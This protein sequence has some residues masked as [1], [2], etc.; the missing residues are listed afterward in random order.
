MDIFKK[1]LPLLWK[2][3]EKSKFWFIQEPWIYWLVKS[4]NFQI[5]Y[6]MTFSKFAQEIYFYLLVA[7]LYLFGSKSNIFIH[8][9]ISCWL[10]C[11]NEWFQVEL[12]W[13]SPMLKSCWIHLKNNN[14]LSYCFAWWNKL[15]SETHKT[16][17]NPEPAICMCSARQVF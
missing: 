10:P 4:Q 2:P 6:I 1:S 9:F 7:S 16:V 17:Q 11:L 12:F 3:K 8:S 15:W 14:F 13:G 5:F